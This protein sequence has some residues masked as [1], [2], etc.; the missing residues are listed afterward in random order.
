MFCCF[1]RFQSAVA[2]YT[3]WEERGLHGVKIGMETY[4]TETTLKHQIN[5]IFHYQAHCNSRM[6]YEMNMEISRVVFTVI[7]YE[8]C[9]THVHDTVTGH[10]WWP[11][12]KDRPFT[13]TKHLVYFVWNSRPLYSDHL[14]LYPDTVKPLT[15]PPPRERPHSGNTLFITMFNIP[16]MR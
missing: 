7:S 8:Q 13:E 11:V 5:T 16:L 3:W 10:N 4:E 14:L 15:R 9:F 2:V 1:F 6:V 12:S